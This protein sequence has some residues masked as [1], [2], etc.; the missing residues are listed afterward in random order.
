MTTKLL[1]PLAPRRAPRRRDGSI[2]GAACAR[3][4]PNGPHAAS[5]GDEPDA[6]API[7]AN[8]NFI[9]DGM[10]TFEWDVRNQLVAVTVGHASIG[11]FVRR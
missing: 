7:V 9:A 11:M 4:N 2:E 1:Q 8:G 3:W 10:R 5:P 6:G